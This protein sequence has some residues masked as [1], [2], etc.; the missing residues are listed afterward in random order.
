MRPSIIVTMICIVLTIF[1]AR[2]LPADSPNVFWGG[3]GKV[4]MVATAKST[5]AEGSPGI[6]IVQGHNNTGFDFQSNGGDER[7]LCVLPD[8]S[9]HAVYSGHSPDKNERYTYYVFSDDFGSTFTEPKQVETRPA[10]FPTLGVT[11]DGRAVVVSHKAK[12]PRCLYFQIDYQKGMGFFLPTNIPDDPPNYALPRVAVPSDSIAVF[13]AFSRLAINSVWNSFNFKTNAFTH[14]QNQEM[15]PGVSGNYGYTHALAKSKNGKVAMAMINYLAWDGEDWMR[16]NDFGENGV[17]VRESLDGGLTFGDPVDITQYGNE[18]PPPFH[19]VWL[20]GLSALYVGE[21]LHLTWVESFLN[22][23]HTRPHNAL[24]I[25]HWSPAV[26]NGIP[27]V[28]VRWDSLHFAYWEGD[29]QIAPIDFPYLGVDEEGVLTISFCSF[30]P[31]TTVKDSLTGYLFSD[32]FAV[33]SADNGYSWGEPTNLTN[34]PEMDDR[35]PYISEWNEAGTINVLY[36]SDTKTG[37]IPWG[38]Q[39][40]GEVDYLFLKTDHPST[41]PYN[42]YTDVKAQPVS[43]PQDFLL[44]RNYPNPFNPATTIEFECPSSFVTLDIFDVL[45]RH[46]KTLVQE[47]RLAGRHSEVWDATDKS[48]RFVSSGVYFAVL[49]TEKAQRTLKLVLMK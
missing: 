17:L 37:Q 16:E 7:R 2:D 1:V 32:V 28:A 22:D 14:E 43:N 48:G 31:D 20:T 21:E 29:P 11:P 3:Q 46:V 30:P 27:T 8:G 13:S 40:V 36:Q 44:L 9:V 23:I 41:E 33:S 26:N 18:L 4:S 24:R 49:H 39:Y 6:S 47:K 38:S 45:G 12:D 35:Y 25:M 15:F 5:P 34:S 19:H 10:E 42:F